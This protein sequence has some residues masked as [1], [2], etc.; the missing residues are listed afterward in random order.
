MPMS[1]RRNILQ[2]TPRAVGKYRETAC[3]S[4]E[5]QLLDLREE[6][7]PVNICLQNGH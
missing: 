5:L 4:S 7:L 1:L 6:R 2:D 3:A